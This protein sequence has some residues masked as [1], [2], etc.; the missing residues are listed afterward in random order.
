LQR[1]ADWEAG[2]ENVGS[3]TSNNHTGRV[4]TIVYAG[5]SGNITFW[6]KKLQ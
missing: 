5:L 6:G 1:E 2:K 4:K 3:G